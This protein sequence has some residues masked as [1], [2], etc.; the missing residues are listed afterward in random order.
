MKRDDWPLEDPKG[1]PV[2]AVRAIRDE[3]RSRVQELVERQGWATRLSAT[4]PSW[5]L[6]IRENRPDYA[7]W[8]MSQGR[9]SP[10]LKLDCLPEE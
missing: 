1:R 8:R 5:E 2:E 9:K 7:A 4:V 6:R 10:R 3:I